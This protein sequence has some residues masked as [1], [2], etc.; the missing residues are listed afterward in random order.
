MGALAQ[1]VE[2]TSA[3]PGLWER[4]VRP[5][6]PD[7]SNPY[8]HVSP[9]IDIAAY[10]FSWAWVLIPMLMASR[11]STLFGIYAFV[12]GA[13]LAHRHYGLPYAYFDRGVFR[14][15]ERKLTFFPQFCIL[16]LAATPLLL[17]HR[18]GWIGTGAVGA[19]VFFSLLWNFWHV[20]MQKFGIMRLY[21]AKVPASARQQAPSF[22]DK[23]FILC[24]IPLYL[25][26]LVPKYKDLILANGPNVAGPVS[27][28][29]G[30]MEKYERWLVLPTAAFAAGG[31]G[32][33]IWWEWRAH[34]LND[35]ENL[36]ADA[37]GQ[38]QNR[39]VE[40]GI[41]EAF[42]DALSDDS[43]SLLRPI[44]IQYERIGNAF[45]AGFPQANIAIS[46]LTKQDACEALE[47]EILDAFDDW[48]ADESV[49]GVGPR[50]Q[51]EILKQYIRKQ[52]T[53]AR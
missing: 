27:A 15:F 4:L 17:S 9:V 44:P 6:H 7:H 20:Y 37:G 26:Y 2:I 23:Y 5:P 22:I 49:L 28:I 12:M 51:L 1:T 33:W 19:M 31:V 35:G 13:N 41:S 16:L 14:M 47:I 18:A 40:R 21:Q 48:M 24:W 10:H 46:G 50:Q 38:Q 36:M 30:F 25:S 3:Q 8:W 53:K 43:H 29:I 32:L 34:R 39:M 45:I 42:I 11:E 52:P